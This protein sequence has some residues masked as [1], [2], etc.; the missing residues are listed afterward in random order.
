VDPEQFDLVLRVARATFVTLNS[1]GRLRG[2]MGVTSPGRPLVTDVSY[3]AHSASTRDPRFPAVRGDEVDGLTISLSILTVPTRLDVG[4][5]DEL[6]AALTIGS[7]GLIIKSGDRRATFLPVMW[8][9]L[10]D[11]EDFLGYLE[12]KGSRAVGTWRRGME[13]WT[14]QADYLSE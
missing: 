6:L 9:Q 10:P 3:N 4:A 8:E 2:C 1:Q 5:R 7:D 13:A 11:A 14:F 12:G